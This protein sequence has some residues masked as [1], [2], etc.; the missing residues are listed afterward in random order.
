MWIWI[1]NKFAKFDAKKI[2]W[3]ENIPKS[4]KGATF[5]W[6][7]VYTIELR[8]DQVTRWRSVDWL[9]ADVVSATEKTDH[10]VQNNLMTVIWSHGQRDGDTPGLSYFYRPDELKYHANNRGVTTINFHG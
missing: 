9:I 3:S 7:T 10:T 6:N 4:F 5:F 2:N 8:V 1:S